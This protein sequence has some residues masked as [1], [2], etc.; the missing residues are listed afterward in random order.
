M[1]ILQYDTER[2]TEICLFDLVDVDA[3]VTDLTIGNIVKA[4][5]QVRDRCFPA[6]VE[7][8]KAIF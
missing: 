6:P 8:T 2:V 5:D 3:V 7:P 4:V 1:G